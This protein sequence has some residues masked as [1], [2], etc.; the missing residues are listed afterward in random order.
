M[1]VVTDSQLFFSK[2]KPIMIFG[3]DMH[4]LV[5]RA[6]T[7]TL[8]CYRHPFFFSNIVKDIN[9]LAIKLNLG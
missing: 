2:L 5:Y 4:I 3:H 6:L 1:Q 8:I 9:N 7:M